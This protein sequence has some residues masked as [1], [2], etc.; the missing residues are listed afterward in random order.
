MFILTIYSFS[1]IKSQNYESQENSRPPTEKKADCNRL[2]FSRI[3]P[4]LNLL[5]QNKRILCCYKTNFTYDNPHQCIFGQ[6]IFS[7]YHICKYDLLLA[8]K[9]IFLLL[10][11]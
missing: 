5:R 7:F 9:A 6:T 8:P 4:F 1:H 3:Y 10:V 11:L 2:P